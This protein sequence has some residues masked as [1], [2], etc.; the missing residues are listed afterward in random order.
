M[1]S[2]E[3]KAECEPGDGTELEAELEDDGEGTGRREVW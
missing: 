3:E 2:A 1:F